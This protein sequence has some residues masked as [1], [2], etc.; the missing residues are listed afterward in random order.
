MSCTR[1][2]LSDQSCIDCEAMANSLPPMDSQ[3]HS[4][5][6][7][8][9]PGKYSFLVTS[10][11]PTP[12]D[13]Q[14]LPSITHYPLH[15]NG[16]VVAYNLPTS[17]RQGVVLSLDGPTMCRIWRGN[18]T[19]WDDP[20]ILATNPLM[21]FASAAGHRIT[22]IM[23]KASAGT[24][25]AF[26]SY[27]N[28]IDPMWA[29]MGIVPSSKP[30]Y[31]T[32]LYANYTYYDDMDTVMSGMSDTLWSFALTT[33][34]YAQK[35]KASMAEFT[36]SK[37]HSFAC[38]TSF[39]RLTAFELGTGSYP[40]GTTMYDLTNPATEYGWPIVTVSYI[41]FDKSNAVTTCAT[42]KSLVEYFLWFYQSP[43]IESIAE[44]MGAISLPSL[45]VD[46]LQIPSRIRNDMKCQSS[47][48]VTTNNDVTFIASSE[49][50]L[51]LFKLVASFYLALD[52]SITYSPTVIVRLR[53]TRTSSQAE[54]GGHCVSASTRAQTLSCDYLILF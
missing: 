12:T 40:P 14:T 47:Q 23:Q 24:H 8:F 46:L 34:N 33:S 38:S 42:K 16:V 31:P 3:L 50:T 10:S 29:T 11:G 49:L 27:C 26:S 51:N 22:M 20:S 18:I 13:Y 45:Y 2:V 1:H 48:L 15:A 21:N 36:N 17:V 28:K 5:F 4:S 19:R 30:N 32:S 41:W 7:F 54:I 25:Q 52:D 43:V 44:A 53:L 37:G 39:V 9:D 35:I 6:L